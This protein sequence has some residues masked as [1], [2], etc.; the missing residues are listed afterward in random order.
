[1][2]PKILGRFF[3]RF[4]FMVVIVVI[5]RGI[6]YSW[7]RF[8]EKV[9]TKVDVGVNC[10]LRETMDVPRRYHSRPPRPTIRQADLWRSFAFGRGLYQI[11]LRR[12]T[13]GEKQNFS[14]G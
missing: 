7:R 6:S 13:N 5:S 3:V 4:Q 8:C 12:K 2:V 1:M 14:R 11:N 9:L 10:R